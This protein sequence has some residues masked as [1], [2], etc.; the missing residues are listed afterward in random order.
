MSGDSEHRLIMFRP[1]LVTPM[2]T[3]T[4]TSRGFLGTDLEDPDTIPYFMWDDPMTVSELRTLLRDSSRSER[5]RLL[6]RIM[7]E[8]R[9]NDVWRFTTPDF[10]VAHWEHLRPHLGRR[11]GFWSFLLDSWRSQRLVGS[12]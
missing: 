12:E 11:L 1:K 9:D 5:F 6:G 8:A 4:Q 7:R 3:T 10:V 2:P